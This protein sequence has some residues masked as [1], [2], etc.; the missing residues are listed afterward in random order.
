[1]TNEWRKLSAEEERV[2]M[3]KGTERPFSGKFENHNAAGVYL[4]RRCGTALYRAEDKFD[5]GC[6]WPSFDAEVPGAVRRQ[7]DADGKRTEIVCAHCDGHLGHVFV[8][9]R[10][11]QRNVRHCVNSISME[12]MPSDQVRN[13][14]A[15]AIFAGGCFWGV[16]YYMQQASGVIEAVSGYIGGKLDY[17][18]Y[19]QVCQGDTGHLEAVEVIFDQHLTNF[20]ALSKRFFEIHDPTQ[21]GRQGPDVGE[22]YSSAIFY[23][24]NTQKAV[25]ERLINQLQ[26]RGYKVVT[27]LLPATRFWPAEDRHQNYYFIKGTKPYC[28]APV[29]RWGSR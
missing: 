25:A 11:T 10:L 9:E 2:I 18:T 26:A 1:M 14:F 21:A 17:P 19:Q 7:P 23:S 5:A 20:E 16:E 4:C 13:H 12:F 28:H 8:G 29:D 27:R 3:Y 22:Q 24:N 6:G 15:R